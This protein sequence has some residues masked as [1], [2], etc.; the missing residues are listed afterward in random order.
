MVPR[1]DSWTPMI[2]LG[3]MCIWYEHLRASAYGGACPCLPEN[4]V[5]RAALPAQTPPGLGS[6]VE[7]LECRVYNLRFGAWDLGCGV[8]DSGSGVYT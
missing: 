7:P 5:E 6:G 8:E 3:T 4:P 2:S 1:D